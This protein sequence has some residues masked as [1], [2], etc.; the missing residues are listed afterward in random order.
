MKAY[1]IACILLGAL[2]GMGVAARDRR[3][4]RRLLSDLTAG[5]TRIGEEVRL[6]RLPLPDLLGRL[7]DDCA[8][9]A[10][11]FFRT[12][13]E[14]VRAGEP[15]GVRWR[16]AVRTLP[17]STEDAQTL[18]ELSTALRGDETQICNAAELASARLER[19]LGD[20]DRRASADLRQSA[21]L[22]FSAAALLVILLY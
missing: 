2:W 9:D 15:P 4:R 7:A 20:M 13:A 14:G 6:S 11:A 16:D 1:G 3:R 21:A 19:S 5:V 22:L 8:P 17:L 18:C 10:A 12:V